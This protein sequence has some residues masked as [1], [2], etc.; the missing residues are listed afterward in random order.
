MRVNGFQWAEFAIEKARDEFTEESLVAREAHLRESDAARRK[1]ARYHFQLRA[2]P[3]AVNSFEDDE[4]AAGR[5]VFEAQSSIGRRFVRPGSWL[6]LSDR[7]SS[8]LNRGDDN[9]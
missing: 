5:H 1:C 8:C 4:F 7:F 9:P 3:G 2:F 6:A